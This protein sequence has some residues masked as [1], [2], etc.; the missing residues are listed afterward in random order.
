MDEE[1]KDRPQKQQQTKIDGTEQTEEF[2][3]F[4]RIVGPEQIV[5]D[6]IR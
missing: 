2:F 6:Q 3:G 4:S 5:A 1:I